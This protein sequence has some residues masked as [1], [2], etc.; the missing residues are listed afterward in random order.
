MMEPILTGHNNGLIAIN[1][2]EA[3]DAERERRRAQMGEPY[4]TLIGHFRHEIGHFYWDLLVK[5]REGIAAFADVFGDPDIDYQLALQNH[6]ANGAPAGWQQTFISAYASSHPWE[7]FAE[8]FA[9]YLHMVDT[10][11]TIGGFGV[12]MA[13]FPGPESHPAAAVPFD[14]Y[15]ATTE[16]LTAAMVPFSFALNTINRSMGQ[17][18]LYPFHLSP[19]I[20]AKIDYVNRLI[21]KAA[22]RSAFSQALAAE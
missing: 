12:T 11:A 10:L 5:D 22:G 13:P 16:Q 17:H 3:D 2:A 9:H 21:A 14:A 15:S 19:A 8:T 20:T 18:D 6:Y 7:D 1:I 4:R